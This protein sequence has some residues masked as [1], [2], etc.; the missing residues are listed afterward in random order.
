MI[1][2][3][4]KDNIECNEVIIDVLKILIS[5]EINCE[6]FEKNKTLIQKAKEIDKSL[7]YILMQNQMKFDFMNDIIEDELN[8]LNIEEIIN[9]YAKKLKEEMGDVFENKENSDKNFFLKINLAK[10]ES[11]YDIYD[12][13]YFLKQLPFNICVSFINNK[14][15]D[16]KEEILL[17]TYMEYHKKNKIE[18][19]GVPLGNEEILFFPK[20]KNISIKIALGKYCVD[21]KTCNLIYENNINISVNNLSDFILDSDDMD[22]LIKDLEKNKENNINNI[23]T[24]NKNGI[25]IFFKKN[26]NQNAYKLIKIIIKV[27]IN[28]EIIKGVQMPMN[29]I[30]EL[31]NNKS[32]YEKIIK[33]KIVEQLFTYLDINL[34]ESK[35]TQIKSVLWILAKLLI[36]ENQGEIIENDFQIIKKIIEFNQECD[37]YAMKGTIVYILCY[38][39]QNKNLKNIIESYNYTY[40]FNTDICYPNNIREIYLDNRSNYINRKINDEVDRITKLIKL[41]SSSEE[42]YN[43]ISSLINNISFKQAITDLEDVYKNNPQKFYEINLFVKIYVVLSKYKF[44]PSSRK[45]ILNY[46]DKAINSID[47]A[48]EAF[49]ILKEVGIDVLTAHQFGI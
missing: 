38:I 49:K 47:F 33:Y 36:K 21:N 3:L 2:C 35:N 23:Y 26:Q 24:I 1:E 6:I 27:K 42:I 25:S 4:N 10:T 32:G 14:N 15:S 17:I 39:S 34:L 13:F 44:K 30:T 7:I 28:P 29:I 18:L 16:K 43:N 19:C 5:E 37:D 20:K 9:D 40:F 31:N 48:Q 11:M 12:E 46:M 8:N 41:P 22:E 45:S